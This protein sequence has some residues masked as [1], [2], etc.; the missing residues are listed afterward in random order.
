[1]W[2][3]VAVRAGTE[4]IKIYNNPAGNVQDNVPK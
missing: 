3:T 1:M 2:D 4:S